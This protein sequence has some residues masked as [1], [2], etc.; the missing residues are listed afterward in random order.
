MHGLPLPRPRWRLI[1]GGYLF[2]FAAGWAYGAGIR[3]SA[4][5]AGAPWERDVILRANTQP[6]GLMERLLAAVPWLGT[7]LTL[8]PIAALVALRCWRRGRRDLATWI[9]VVELGCLSLTYLLKE[10]LERDRP[11]LV[12]RVGWFGWA[13]YPSGHAMAA[14]AVLLTFAV[15]LWREKG[16]HWPIVVAIPIPALIAYSRIY[17]GVHWPTDIVGGALVGLVWLVVTLLGFGVVERRQ[18]PRD[19]PELSL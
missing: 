19:D 9:A 15:A 10:L 12:A 13:S 6:W 2:A 18:E 7:N 14:I 3:A 1:I 17:H 16:W 5:W 8:G 11:D 4:G